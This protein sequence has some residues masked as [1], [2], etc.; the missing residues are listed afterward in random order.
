M[1]EEQQVAHEILVAKLGDAAILRNYCEFAALYRPAVVSTLLG[2]LDKDPLKRRGIAMEIAALYVAALEDLVLWFYALR[3]WR[4]NVELLFDVVDSVFVSEGASSSTSSE[5]ALA[6]IAG[7]TPEQL[8]AEFGLPDDEWL[9]E[10]GWTQAV[11]AEHKDG[12]A[13][14]LSFV[15]EAIAQRT[16]DEGILVTS[17]NKIKHGALAIAA[18]E[19]SAIGVSVMLASRRGPLDETSGKRKI[20]T[21][22][23][24][25]DDADIREIANSVLVTSQVTWAILNLVYM[26]RCDSTWVAPEW[27]FPRKF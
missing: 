21:G 13:D 16:S 14:L 25:C 10:N 2:A 11:L 17:Y 18:T 3:R 15:R 20:N 26:Y 24:A 9:L 8:R 23:I 5:K 22:W 4:P 6:E 19:N 12:I 1:P 7:W 27:P